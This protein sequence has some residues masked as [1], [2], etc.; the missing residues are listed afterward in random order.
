MKFLPK[1]AYAAAL[2]AVLLGWIALAIV[3]DRYGPVFAFAPFLPAAMIAAWLGG[4]APTLFTVAISCLIVIYF[5]LAPGSLI[6]Q[7]KDGLTAL[8][9]FLCVNLSAG[10][11]AESLHKARRA[12]EAA[13]ARLAAVFASMG[14]AVIVV[15]VDG[16]VASLNPL[17]ERLTGW[18]TAEA[19]G[20]P[21]A[22]VLSL[23]YERTGEAA[24]DR[25]AHVVESGRPFGP[26]EHVLLQTR[27]GQR[28]PIEESAAP[29][30]DQ[31]GAI[32]GVVIILRDCT[33]ERQAMAARQASERAA[34]E[35]LN[36]LDHVYR[37]A[38]VG[39]GLVDSDLRY[40]RMNDVLA[41]IDGRS[42]DD[43]VGR[44]IREIVPRLADTLEP[45]YRQV[46]DTGKALVN[47]EVRGFVSGSPGERVWLVSYFPVLAASGQPSGV[48]S[49]VLDITD[50]KRGEDALREADQRKN[51]FLAMLAHELR[52]PLATI[53]HAVDLWRLDP[54]A[55]ELNP[56]EI[57]ERQV[58]HLSRLVDD[59]LDLSRINRGKIQLKRQPSDA[60]ELVRRS[61][62]A[63]RFLLA[64]R[65]QQ[66]ELELPDQ[67][68]ILSV[69]PTRFEQVLQNL[70]HNAGKYSEPGGAISVRLT[71]ADGVAVLSVADQGMG[72]SAELLPHVFEPF[73]QADRSLDRAEGGLG[74]GLTLVREI[75]LLH[76]G[77]V[78][79]HSDGAGRGSRFE[80]R[81][82][83]S[84]R[85]SL[86]APLP[87]AL[88]GPQRSLRIL[89]VE[90]HES[91]A[92]AL[93]SLLRA[94]GH[95][96]AHCATGDG[97]LAAAERFGPHV[98]L[99]DLGL[100]GK[101]GARVAHELRQE[102]G[103]SELRIL[104]LSGYGQPGAATLAHFDRWLV[105]PVD[106]ATLQQALLEVTGTLAKQESAG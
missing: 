61:A 22:G 19:A 7:D 20:L 95:E 16:K 51:E 14:D 75:V 54:E 72:I 21:I 39:M 28:T 29:I 27:D 9:I 32:T 84:E 106:F 88:N 13:S 11:L 36:L 100:P 96:T 33:R 58:L 99:L 2:L 67:P 80:V 24:E 91:T 53:R 64:Q 52:N 66:L 77:S 103:L 12:A 41:Q 35:R 59:L 45:L 104:A 62:E 86:A 44:T 4:L 49:V 101:D 38:P 94:A 56:P 70:L 3:K 43:C 63:A 81:L 23:V 34:T 30:R 17:A 82:P 26:E 73:T 8:V 71:A 102:P 90:D 55:D 85:A 98:V 57:I 89:V 42:P 48:S 50:R 31:S 1:T 47:R 40:V 87:V 76:R 18:T 74:I 78:S 15:D 68:L 79:A 5:F 105:K 97:A 93:I 10:L 65:R 25:I 92:R 69:D 37:T 60:A 46:L 6:L 83:L